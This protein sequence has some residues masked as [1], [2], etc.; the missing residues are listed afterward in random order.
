MFRY[1]VRVP[2]W[3]KYAC[4]SG[5]VLNLSQSNGFTRSASLYV[6][7]QLPG[8]L[9]AVC[10]EI[11]QHRGRILVG[12]TPTNPRPS[13]RS[14]LPIRSVV[15]LVSPPAVPTGE[16]IVVTIPGSSILGTLGTSLVY[17]PL[18]TYLQEK[19][20]CLELKLK[21]RLTAESRPRGWV[22]PTA[23]PH[24]TAP[25]RPVAPKPA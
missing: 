21:I 5:L 16:D 23:V 10:G 1:S 7:V 22:K 11:P 24:R 6:P 3:K 8:M 20:V 18:R 14:S 15:F 25:F 12:M 4:K 9:P 17:V 13:C 2:L 19:H